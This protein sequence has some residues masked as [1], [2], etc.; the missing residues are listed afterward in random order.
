MIDEPNPD[1]QETFD[2]LD[3]HAETH[4]SDSDH[5]GWLKSDV[6]ARGDEWIGRKVGQFEILR[7]IGTG[8]MGNVY[9]ARQVRPHRSVALKIVKSAAA[10]P[11]ALHRFE[12]ESEMLARL[13]HHGIAQ[14]FHSGKQEHD[15][16]VYPYF[17][18][19]YIRGSRSITDFAQEEHLSRAGRL[20]LFLMVCDAVQYGHGRGV[21]HRDLKPTNI[22]ITDSGRPKVIDFGV[23]MLAKTEEDDET[24]SSGKF[25]GTFQ[26]ASPEQCGEDPHDV[27][28]RTDVYSLGVI[29]YQLMVNQ[30]PYDL[31]GIPIHRAPA[32]VKDTTPKNVRSIDPSIPI[33]T[34]QILMKALAKERE[35]RYESVAELAM[36]IRRFINDQPI[37]ATSPTSMHRLA[38]Y[39]KRNRLKFRAAMAVFLALLIGLT[40][41]VWGMV[42][43]VER[44]KDMQDALLKEEK[45]RLVAEQ[46]AYTAT[47]GTVQAA[48]ANKSWEMAR[49]HLAATHRNQR[50]WEWNYLQGMVDQSIRK[51]LIGDRPISLATAPNGRHLAVSFDGGRVVLI[52]E[53]R[54]ISRDLSLPSRVRSMEFANNSELLLLGMADGKIALLDL[55]KDTLMFIRGG[56]S[57]VESIT[58]LDGGAYAT[59]HTDGFVRYWSSD[60]DVTYEVDCGSGMV[61]SLAYDQARSRLAIGTADG[62]VQVWKI[63]SDTPMMKTRGHSGEAHVV[64][65]LPDGTLI[66]AGDDDKLVV[67]NARSMKKM[68]SIDSNHG[69]ILDV[70]LSGN[71]IASVG[72]D[73]VVRL[74]SLPAY[75]L[76]EELRG[77][78][79]FIWSIGS[80]GDGRIVSVG[81]DGSIRWWDASGRQPTAVEISTT[82]P[83]SDIAFVW[84]EVLV[85]VSEFDSR[86]QVVNVQTGESRKIPSKVDHVLTTVEF[87]PTT[88]TVITGDVEGQVRLWDV[89][90]MK[91]GPL[92]GSCK[93][94]ISSMDV[95]QFGKIVAVGTFGGQI[96]AWDIQQQTVML[97]RSDSDAI[98]LSVLF[99][100]DSEVLFVSTSDGLISAFKVRSGKTIWQRIGSGSDV[101]EMA[102][103]QSR[104]A[105]LTATASNVIQL[106]DVDTGDVVESID[107]TGAPLRDI[108]M[109][110]DGSRFAT[111]LSDG[112]IGIW[113]VDRFG[114]VASFPAGQLMECIDVSSDGYL[115]AVSG[116]NSIIQIKDGMSRGARLTN[117]P[118]E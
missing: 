40:G 34:E 68:T 25:V 82:M 51:W 37:H 69:G 6:G 114:P 36:D 65:F 39:A 10:T 59:G 79:D 8:G 61:L 1:G 71:R 27:D 46:T 103:V 24:E 118:S 74:W 108:V 33:E 100:P 84:N 43:S 38:L 13:Q 58:M 73:G 18:M 107:T 116:G 26:W 62:T 78:G 2:D 12:M 97:D 83:V 22:L 87:V 35:L 23:A 29:L 88:S 66:S 45:A 53:E 117:S 41:L 19:E 104:S 64:L 21:I 30:L 15:G 4:D 7:I 56:I 16:A 57:S 94:Q 96:R 55:E 113:S 60:G 95:S 85:A 105:I 92:I 5:K 75:A 81:R 72:M 112:T 93:R 52:D 17:A 32:I 63:D 31:K 76:L 50:G 98:V 106:L 44:R 109:F 80:L 101:V 20:E 28:I 3:P 67:W 77:H 111:I 11:A 54:N 14:V 86:I 9:E 91:S 90:A 115:L 49:H 48:I 110:P 99:S 47:I 89:D 102:N 42:K 70:A